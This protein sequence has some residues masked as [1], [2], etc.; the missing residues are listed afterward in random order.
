MVRTDNRTLEK[1]PDVL[2][3]IGMNIASYPFLNTMIDGLMLET[4]KPC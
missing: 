1:A 3:R 2:N 4:E